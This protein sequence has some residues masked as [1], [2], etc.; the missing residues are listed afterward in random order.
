T[1]CLQDFL[2]TILIDLACGITVN[3]QPLG[4]G[5]RA[6]LVVTALSCPSTGTPGG[7]INISVTARNQGNATAAGFRVGLYFSP[8]DLITTGDILSASCNFAAGVPAG[9]SVSC[10]GSITVPNTL[11]GGTYYFGALADDLGV[12]SESNESNNGR[13][14]GPIVI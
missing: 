4:G 9:G 3:C 14:A 7:Q 10:S 2:R 8:N 12:V 5:Q 13:A 6:D 11:A 1:S